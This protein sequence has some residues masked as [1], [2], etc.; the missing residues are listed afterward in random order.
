MWECSRERDIY[1]RVLRQQPLLHP[2]RTVKRPRLS[3]LLLLAGLCVVITQRTDG[4]LS[5]ALKL[6]QFDETDSA[7]NGAVC[8]TRPR[9]VARPP[10]LFPTRVPRAGPAPRVADHASSS[11]SSPPKSKPRPRGAT[12]TAIDIRRNSRRRRAALAF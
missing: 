3:F 8:S 1:A 5:P 6:R 11:S 12:T 10:D 4:R 2:R 7:A 9:A